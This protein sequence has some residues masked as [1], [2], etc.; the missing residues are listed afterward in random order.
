MIQFFKHI[1]G[2]EGGF[3][4]ALF[5]SL[6]RAGG[7]RPSRVETMA[8]RQ[9]RERRVAAAQAEHKRQ[10]PLHEKR[11]KELAGRKVGREATKIAGAA[12]PEGGEPVS[13]GSSILSSQSLI[14]KKDE[15]NK[16]L[17]SG[18]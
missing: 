9:A 6:F 11:Q 14:S 4:K 8:E 12:Q 15:K 17:I 10:K 5:S 1:L 13:G 7:V 18:L 3:F 2:C 16:S